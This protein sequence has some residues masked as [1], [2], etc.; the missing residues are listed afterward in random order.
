MAFFNEID[1]RIMSEAKNAQ[2]ACDQ[3]SIQAMVH[4]VTHIADLLTLA[5]THTDDFRKAYT[6]KSETTQKRTFESL[7]SLE[8][9]IEALDSF[10]AQTLSLLTTLQE[11]SQEE[12]TT[13]EW[14]L[15]RQLFQA[16]T[17]ENNP[18]KLKPLEENK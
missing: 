4:H 13:Q 1:N 5:Q 8:Q 17:A 11:T 2:I 3:H 12:I 16:F 6:E 18:K 14:Q 10:R 9:S 7:S 15:M